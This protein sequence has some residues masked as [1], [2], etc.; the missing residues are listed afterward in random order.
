MDDDGG[1]GVGKGFVDGGML[2]EGF[3]DVPAAGK[4]S[5]GAT[6]GNGLD[7]G[8]SVDKGFVGGLDAFVANVEHAVSPFCWLVVLL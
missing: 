7:D 2:L 6:A 8:A 3:D 1:W 4:T 5:V